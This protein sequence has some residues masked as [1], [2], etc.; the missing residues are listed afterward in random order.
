MVTLKDFIAPSDNLIFIPQ[1]GFWSLAQ[2]WVLL[3]FLI[4]FSPPL[5]EVGL[6]G[7][8]LQVREPRS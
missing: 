7:P 2:C 1:E 4:G 3:S 5:Q 8:V 6:I